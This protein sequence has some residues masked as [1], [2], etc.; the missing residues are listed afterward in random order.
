M[1]KKLHIDWTRCDG[2]GLC[3]ELLPAVLGR[4]DWGYPV[5]RHP[6]NGDGTNATIG[7]DEAQAARDAVKLCPK[8]AL[9]LQA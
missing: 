7:P 9:V 1:N 2:R 3:T 5:V 8:L 4:D 6:R